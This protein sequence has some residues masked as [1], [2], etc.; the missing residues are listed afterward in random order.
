MDKLLLGN[1]VKG[2]P[3]LLEEFLASAKFAGRFEWRE[4]CGVHSLIYTGRPRG[5]LYS[6][7]SNN[8]F[9][10]SFLLFPS[11]GNQID[12]KEYDKEASLR[13]RYQSIEQMRG[14]SLAEIV[15]KLPS[16]ETIRGKDAVFEMG[17]AY[18]IGDQLVSDVDLYFRRQ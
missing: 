7:R 14:A 1:D 16:L 3:S 9:S 17:L 18:H 8:A 4:N 11:A 10:P 13:I 6:L 15:A 12:I 2:N 5:A